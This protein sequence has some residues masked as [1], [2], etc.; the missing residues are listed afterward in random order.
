MS[1]E[2][3]KSGYTLGRPNGIIQRRIGAVKKLCDGCMLWLSIVTANG[4]HRYSILRS[5]EYLCGDSLGLAFDSAPR[6][7]R[8]PEDNSVGL[9]G[10][11]YSQKRDNQVDCSDN[12]CHQREDREG[13]TFHLFVLA[14][15]H[16]NRVLVAGKGLPLV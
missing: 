6:G 11:Q 15:D 4:D 16:E 13:R 3:T 8:D 9:M 14:R 12:R 1:M 2:A 10:I 7:T 5:I